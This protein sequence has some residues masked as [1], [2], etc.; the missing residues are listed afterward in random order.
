MKL[1]I[2]NISK[3]YGQ[4]SALN[5]FSVTLT[6]GVYGFLGPN[7]AGKTTLMNILCLLL[8]ADTGTVYL[9]DKDI[10]LQKKKYL[11]D[12][13]YMPQYAQL[14]EDFTLEEYLYYI[15]ALKK[16]EKNQLEKRV[17]KL[18]Q[19][20]NLEKV[21]GNKL[22]TFSGGMKQ[23][24][25]LVQA[26]LNDP[27]ILILDEPTA[28]LDP[29][30]RIKVRNLIAKMSK[31][32]IVLISTHVVGDVEFI[33]NKIILIQ[34]GYC[35]ACQSPQQLLHEIHGKVKII[36]LD[37]SNVDKFQEQYLVSSLFYENDRLYARVIDKEGKYTEGIDTYPSLEDVYIYY[38]GDK[39]EIDEI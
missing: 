12:I 37:E 8:K 34:E 36:P 9:D 22:K 14:Y 39:N 30:Q 10:N 1:D 23:R 17:D 24:A 4:I 38:F 2:Q 19:D 35:I 20:V 32:K 3:K 26:L 27:K 18:L 15:G 5:E 25:M 31:D 28:G 6:E 16:I 33:S 11:S 21:R 13:G 7:G 29:N